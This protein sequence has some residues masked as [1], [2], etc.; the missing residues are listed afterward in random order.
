V[1]AIVKED[2]WSVVQRRKKERI[3]PYEQA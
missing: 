2:F 1:S 3:V